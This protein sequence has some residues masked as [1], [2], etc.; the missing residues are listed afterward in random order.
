MHKFEYIS[1]SLRIAINGGLELEKEKRI[2]EYLEF[3]DSIEEIPPKIEDLLAK[4][5]REM[6]RVHLLG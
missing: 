2:W 4:S 3:D 5:E 6:V 1:R